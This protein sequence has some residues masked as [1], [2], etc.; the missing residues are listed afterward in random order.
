MAHKA[1][2]NFIRANGN[3]IATSKGGYFI[4]IGGGGGN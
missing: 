3:K 1:I 2:F 4:A